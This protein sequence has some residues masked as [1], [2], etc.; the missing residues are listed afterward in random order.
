MAG[1]FSPGLAGGCCGFRARLLHIGCHCSRFAGG[2]DGRLRGPAFLF[3]PARQ[4]RM[5]Q[6]V[7]IGIDV[8]GTNTDAVL[9]SGKDVLTS[10]K[11]ATTQDVR[12]GVV[13]VVSRLIDGWQGSRSGISA[14]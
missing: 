5:T 4:G 9:M 3:F 10:A 6:A 7:R 12:S 11:T 1:R 2:S 14:V 13:E 8:G